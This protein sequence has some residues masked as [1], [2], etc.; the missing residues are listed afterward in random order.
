MN[1]VRALQYQSANDAELSDRDAV[2]AAVL[3][4]KNFA[5]KDEVSSFCIK[6]RKM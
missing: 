5:E 2:P 4:R 6:N 1:S 3:I